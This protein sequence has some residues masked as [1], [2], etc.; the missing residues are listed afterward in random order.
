MLT[1]RQNLLETIHG[2][3]PDRFVN[4]FEAFAL[5]PSDPVSARSASPV[6]GGAPVKDSWGV[7]FSF[8]ENVPGA[9]PVHDGEHTV[10]QD[11]SQWRKVV[12]APALNYP[13]EEWN[14]FRDKHVLPIDRSDKFVTALLRPGV[15]ER[16]HFLMGMEECMVSMY[17]DPEELQSLIEYIT[18][19]EVAYAKLLCKH[20]HPDAILHHDDWG[21]G[22]N[23]FLSPEMFR[24]FIVPAYKRIY[25]TYRENGVELIVHHSDSYCANLVPE[26]I[27]MGIDIWQG[28][29]RCN[30]IPSLIS[31]YGGRISF[32]GGIDSTA[33]DIE[34]WSPELIEQVARGACTACGKHYYIP[35]TTVGGP[36]DTYPGVYKSTS[37]VIEK[38]SKEFFPA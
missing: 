3:T 10:V 34:G 31:Q 21:S 9:Y 11:L 5:I 27:D 1:K 14:A 37:A 12:K 20:F 33:V 38:L 17:T 15:F 16:A 32:M 2:G 23:S 7:T 29:L 24:Q 36:G 8:P 30:D 35:N 18:D 19:W 26:M 4:Q 25:G 6:K 22:Q 13:E 28:V